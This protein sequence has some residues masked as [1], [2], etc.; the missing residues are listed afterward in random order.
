MN[1]RLARH[2]IRFA[3][4]AA[5]WVAMLPAHANFAADCAGCHGASN[6][7]FFNGANASNIINYAN[8]TMGASFTGGSTA[9]SIAT[10]IGGML[11]AFNPANQ[12]IPFQSGGTTFNLPNIWHSQVQGTPPGA[13]SSV[14]TVSGPAKGS[15][16]YPAVGAGVN[17]QATYTPGACQVGGDTFT[18][19]ASGNGGNTSTRTATV[20]IANPASPPVINSAAPPA[21]KTGVSYSHTVTVSACTSLVTFSVFSGSL[22]PGLALNTSSGAITGTPTTLG[23]FNGT[24]RATYV[25]GQFDSQAFSITITQGPPAITSGA[26]AGNAAVGVAYSGYT[27]TATNSPTSYGGSGLPPGLSVVPATGAVTGVPSNASGSP[28]VATLTASNGV[29]PDGTKLV[30]FN[31]APAISSAASANGQTGVAFNYQITPGPGPAYTSYAALDPLPP[32]LTLNSGSGAITGVPTTQGSTP[33]RLTGTTGAGATSAQFTLTIN[34]GL[35]PP[36]ITSPLIAAG[37]ATVPFSYQITAT[38]PPHTGF[39]ATPLPAGLTVN[40][41]TGL[42]SGTPAPG[43]GGPY[44]VTISATNATNTGQATLALTISENPPVITSAATASGTTGVAFSYQITATNGVT[45]FGATG[46]PPGVT[47]N[48][49]SG[50]ISGTPTAPGTFN[51][52]MTVTN[53]SGSDSKPLTITVALGPPAITSPATAGG[54]QGF[55]F[56]YQITATNT[57]TSFNA[58]GLPAGLSVNT[59]TGLISGTPTGIGTFTASISATNATATATQSLTITL[60]VGIP[61]FTS[62]ASASG[63]TGLAFVHQLTAT[64]NP[65]SF[66]ASGLPPGLAIDTVTGLISGTPA[67]AGTFS[68]NA[69]ATN[70]TGTGTQAL[71]ITITL[72]PPIVPT[73]GSVTGVSGVPF[74]Y[75]IQPTGGASA[76]S[77]SG[78]PPGLTLNTSS[79]IISGTPTTGG[80]YN[81]AIGV[82]NAA[83]T[84]TFSLTII[85]TF[86]LPTVAAASASVPFETATEITL[87]ITGEAY[88]VTIVSL[89]SHGLV[90]VS[91]NVATYTPATG[92]LGEDSFSYTATNASGTTAAAV[93]SINVTPV[94]PSARAARMTVQINTPTTFD[95]AAF[96][97]GSGVTGVAIRGEPAHGT[98]T[99]N[100]TRVTYKPR[101]DYFGADSFTYVAFSSVGASSTATVTVEVVGRP[102][103]SQDRDVVGLVDAQNQAARR[104]AGAQIGNLNRRMEAL[105]RSEPVP[106]APDEPRPA[107]APRPGAAPSA[108]AE[109]VRL[110]DASAAQ[111]ETARDV[112]PLSL[113]TTLAQAVTART[114]ALD[115]ATA[116]SSAG[117]AIWI[118]G[119]AQFGN[120]D[121]RGDRSG[122]RFGTDGVTLG[123]DR[124]FGERVALGLAAGFARDESKIGSSGTRNRTR[125]ASVAGYGSFQA[126][127]RTFIDALLGYGKLDFDSDR[128]VT[129]LD[130]FARAGRKGRQLFGSVAGAYEWRRDNLLVSPYGRIDFSRDRLDAVTETGAGSYALAY[131]A[132][133]QRVTQA[134][135]GVR[136]ESRHET[137]FGFAQPRARIEYR[138]DFGG[139]RHASLSY[140]DLVGGPEYT[141]STAGAS[142]NALLLGVGADLVF[143]GG[144]RLGFD[145]TGQ[146]ASGQSNVQGVRIMVT[147]ELD[148]P[149]A[150][151][152]LEPL[153]FRYPINVDFSY[154]YDDNVNRARESS[155][156]RWDNVFGM[157]ANVSRNWPLG[158]NLRVQTT[159][160]ASG[161]KFDRHNGLGRF[162]GGAQAE[163]QYRASGAFDAT[164]YSLVGRALYEQYESYYRTGPRYFLG[165]NARRA[166]TDRIEL[167]GE[168]GANVRRGNSEV[169]NWKDYAAKLNIDYALGRKGTLYLAGEYRR[170]DTVSTGRPSLA[171]VGV[172]DVFVVDDAYE[173][174]G[175]I[176]YRFDA[177]TVIGTLGVNWPLGG[178]DS[179]DLSWRYVRATPRRN[180]TFDFSGPKSYIDNQYSLVYLMRF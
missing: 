125:G 20:S 48:A 61:V 141:I 51:A 147:Q 97:K 15:V 106:S 82:T 170:G 32:G 164:T 75:T 78:L 2:G 79:G 11:P 89:P 37:G 64:N 133:D 118:T 117:T 148:A 77:A 122:A 76:F 161:E 56:S 156:K 175:F 127:P 140:A 6:E 8:T 146:R 68:V 84:T 36:V 151:A 23:T 69:S 131:A 47:V 176:S 28:Y 108:R 12:A 178:R 33:V 85:I 144:L 121:E 14:S 86:P 66:G 46:L 98:V 53:G 116:P 67:A 60:G 94:P 52:T 123:V 3:L 162:S 71:T 134:A 177:S 103:P 1:G 35:G 145:Y 7:K 111:R 104:F 105:H 45:V 17:Y 119:N 174:L 27:I 128:H 157:S 13:T 43:S 165:F 63:G 44:S 90:S 83:G 135:L 50:L 114:V 102:D 25:G 180:P 24:I 80:T 137:E 10:E 107:Q 38:N 41:T 58:T 159:A 81:V 30:T 72:R 153:I 168:L 132:Q 100:G 143:R 5:A 167:F 110:A 152:H 59:S 9:A 22:P 126:G 93:V 163:L 31:V 4:I 73:G 55:P 158:T 62:V 18:Y 154:S 129:A 96:I 95:L 130:E 173:G 101:T 139:E 42:I 54:A 34:I 124:R 136:A 49:S 160:L 120:V 70:S 172:A 179:I 26:T 16:S 155:E 109:P 74:S 87:P 138:R 113:A 171:S 65:T 150:F 112:G 166:L 19:R 29:L 115:G 40:P 57:P 88:T 21:G 149:G 99:V 92:Y 142:R 169:F 91:G 39:A